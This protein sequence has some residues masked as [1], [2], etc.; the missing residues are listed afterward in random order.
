MEKK[1]VVI[2]QCETA[3][4]RCSGFACTNSFYEKLH[5][6]SNYDESTRYLA[7]TCGGCSGKGISARLE[8]F[9]KRSKLDKKNV[10]V[11]FATC[12]TNDNKH[13]LRC[14]HIDFMKKLVVKKGFTDIVE[15]SYFSKTATTRRE[16]GIYETYS[17]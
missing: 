16:Q 10:S 14:P 17:Q 13:S 8:N 11:H 4:Q 6:F 3:R 12:I 7:M 15:G 9:A 2:I 1:Y 5:S